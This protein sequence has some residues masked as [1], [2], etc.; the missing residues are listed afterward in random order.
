MLQQRSTVDAGVLRVVLAKP[1][2]FC[3]GVV[4]AID[5]VEQALERYQAPVYVRH[6]IV[7][8][9]HV[10]ERLREKGAI[11]VDELSAVPEGALT[12][13]SAHGVA[14]SIEDEARERRLPVI[15]A[16]CPLVTK[17]HV[18]G[19]RYAKAG[20]TLVLIGHQGHAEVDGTMGQVDAPIY[21]VQSVED[22]AAL[23]F[24]DDTPIAYVTQTTLSVDDT[25][26]I[27]AALKERFSDVQGPDVS[28]I[29]Y[30]TQNRQTAV[31]DLAAVSDLLI[32]VGSSTSSNSNRLRE[33]G[34]EMGVPSYL[35]DDGSGVDPA[36]LD[37]VD[38]VGITAG[39]S[40]PD[41]LVDNVIDA[42]RRLRP[43]EVTQLDGVE[44][45]L[46]FSLPPELRHREPR[47]PRA[48]RT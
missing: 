30:A 45:T 28:E 12:I 32:V 17:V 48:Q 26:G 25:R 15:D 27:I 6:E 46:H 40:A 37:G 33:I 3:A 41:E 42:L 44:E 23:P 21:L 5:I 31:R 36:W 43:V 47:P 18:Q 24:A 4:R 10:V 2:G 22:V 35:V 20:R 19:R 1:R 16:T 34:V 38:T 29:C 9:R 8:N 13:F 14:R 7:H 39:A 11:F